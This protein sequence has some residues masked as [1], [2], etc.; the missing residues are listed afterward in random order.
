MAIFNKWLGDMP[1]DLQKVN[2]NYKLQA[3][4]TRNIVGKL[5]L[6]AG[7]KHLGYVEISLEHLSLDSYNRPYLPGNVDFNISHSGDY[8]VCVIGEDIKVG[9]D[10]ER[11]QAIDFLNMKGI[12]NHLEWRCIHMSDHPLQEF[13]RFWTVKEAA[14]KAAGVGFLTTLYQEMKLSD[15]VIYMNDDMWHY[16]ELKIDANYCGHLVTSQPVSEVVLKYFDFGSWN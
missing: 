4:R 12:M 13:F 3:D 6:R 2:L 11:V 1:V 8:V 9:I 10:I 5:L 16:Q 7:L 15:H 14:L